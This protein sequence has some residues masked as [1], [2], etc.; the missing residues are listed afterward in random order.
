MS[1]ESYQ[2]HL[3]TETSTGFPSSLMEALESVTVS[4][5]DQAP[6]TFEISFTSDYVS[7]GF[8]NMQI[9][10]STHLKIGERVKIGAT[11]GTASKL[12]IDGVITQVAYQPPSDSSGGTYTVKG[13]DISYFMD[14]VDRSMEYPYCVDSVIVAAILTPYMTLGLIPEITE[15]LVGLLDTMTTPQQMGTDRQTVNQMAGTHGYIFCV[16]TNNLTGSTRAYWGA[17]PYSD[18][19]Q[20]AL[21]LGYSGNGNVSELQ[22]NFDGTQ[23]TRIWALVENKETDIPIPIVTVTSTSMTDFSSQPALTESA[24]LTAKNKAM[25]QQGLSVPTAWARAQALTNCSADS[26]VTGQGKVDALRY[27]SILM[28]PGVV[29]VSGAGSLYDGKYY[30][31]T[32]T[33]H[34]TRTAYEQSFSITRDGIGSTLSTVQVAS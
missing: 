12:L 21:V 29:A 20:P 6:Q 5:S 11:V 8:Q 9:A 23:P 18:D 27:G 3:M 4:Q 14:I 13:E 26:A 19:I 31:K 28:A 10:T 15:T 2:V 16:R 33:H 7:S 22:F 32:A 17:P 30:L 24:V 1:T 25:Y 34:I